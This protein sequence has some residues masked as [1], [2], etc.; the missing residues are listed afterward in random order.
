MKTTVSI[1]HDVFVRAERFA[2]RS[3]R[4]RSD[5]YTAALREYL[6]RYERDDVTDVMNRACDAIG[7]GVDP[8]VDVAGHRPLE[9][10]E[11]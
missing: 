2:T 10:S 6:G 4:S 1:P 7:A 11:W 9:H 8:F 5:L 3:G